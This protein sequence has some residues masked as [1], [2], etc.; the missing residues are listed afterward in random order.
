[1]S[2][3]RRV[4]SHTPPLLSCGGCGAETQIGSEETAQVHSATHSMGDMVLCSALKKGKLAGQ[5]LE[6]E[7]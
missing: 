5:P 6:P 2:H 3:L 7:G 1:M 4:L